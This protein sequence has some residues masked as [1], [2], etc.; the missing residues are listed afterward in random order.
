MSGTRSGDPPPGG[1][2][3]R[4][5]QTVPA[6]AKPTNER[7]LEAAAEHPAVLNELGRLNIEHL[8]EIIRAQKAETDWAE[9]RI[10]A[11]ES[12]LKVFYRVNFGVGTFIFVLWAVPTVLDASGIPLLSP[13]VVTEKV[14]LALIAGSVAQIGGLAYAVGRGLFKERPS[15]PAKP[16]PP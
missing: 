2:R 10:R 1:T 12:I 11:A 13:P 9:L 7:P 4:P 8:S 6:A 3:R 15:P 14:L 16:G 5:A